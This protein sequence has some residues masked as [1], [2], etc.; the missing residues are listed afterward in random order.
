MSVTIDNIVD[1]AR[2]SPS[3]LLEVEG[4]VEGEAEVAVA[5]AGE[6]KGH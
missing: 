1:R 2:L 5:V 3:G 4:E 6:G